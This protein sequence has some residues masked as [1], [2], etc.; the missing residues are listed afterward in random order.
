VGNSIS[1]PPDQDQRGIILHELD[2]TI[3]VEAAA[4][5]GKTTAM[6]GR[7][8]NL[9]ASGKCSVDTLAAVTFTRKAAA[10]LRSRF[11][12]QLEKAY[13]RADG[14]TGRLLK[15]ALSGLE[16]CFIG[17][18]HSFCARMLR[19]RPVEAGV[20]IAFEEIDEN[21][22]RTF[23]EQAWDQYVASLYADNSP[24]LDQLE[25]LGVEIGQLRPTFMR[26]ADYPDVDSWP[27]RKLSAPDPSSAV[28][29]LE[30]LVRHME[31][32]LPSLPE[33]YGNDKLMPKYRLIPLMFRQ[34]RRNRLPEVM[35]ILA[36]FK[37]AK[38]VQKLW[39]DGPGQAK[40]EEALWNEFTTEVAQ[41]LVKAWLEYRYEPLLA[42]IRP[43]V[44]LYDDL[45]RR[46]GKLNYQ[47]LLMCAARLLKD[48]PSV[49]EYFRKRFTHLLVD[50]FQDTDPVQ[51]EVL[52]YLTADDLNET[53]WRNCRPVPGSLFVVGD[54]KQSI[55]RFRRADIVTYNRVKQ[56]I[57][58]SSGLVAYLSANFRTTR[59][60]VDW[61]NTVFSSDFAAYPAECSPEYVPL[62]PVRDVENDYG[63][64]KIRT[65]WIPK[66]LR[67]VEEIVDLEAGIIART[68]RNAIDRGVP[69]PRTPREIEAGIEPKANPADFLIVTP[70]TGNLGVYGDKLQ[71]LGIPHQVTGGSALNQVEE[72]LLLHTCLA[73]II[74]PDNPVALVAVLRS[75]LFG[76]S[77][78]ALYEFKRCRGR[79]SFNS[80]VPSELNQAYRQFFEDAFARLKQYA[81]WMARIPAVAAIE[82]IIYDLG[83]AAKSAAAIGGDVRAGSLAKAVELLRSSQ[84]ESWTPAEIVA[85][86]AKI[87]KHEE[88]H[89]SVPARSHQSATVRIMNLHK[90]KGLE[91][92]IVFLADPSGRTNRAPNLH[93]DR[94]GGEAVGYM[95]IDGNVFSASS[96]VLAQPEQWDALAE[97]ENNFKK[98]ENLRLLYVAATRAGCGLT[99]SQRETFQNQNP[100]SY[101][102]PK[103][104]DFGETPDPGPQMPLPRPT[105]RL[106]DSDVSD[107]QASIARRWARATEH[108]YAVTSVKTAAVQRGKLTYSQGEHGTEWGSVIHIL[109]QSLMLNPESDLGNLAA[110][111]LAD[112]GLDSALAEDA[113]ETARSVTRSE[114]WLR[115]QTSKRVL[116]E[117]PFQILGAIEDDGSAAVPTILRGVVDLAFEEPDGWVIIDYKSDRVSE[118]H[119]D[120]LVDLYKPQVLSYSDAWR[121]ITGSPVIETGLYFTFCSRY[122]RV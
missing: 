23:R 16:R 4:G 115:A 72:L 80:A 95:T 58:M 88:N 41:P 76:I 40:A 8:V 98:A 63:V 101:F 49:R 50:E 11:Q 36:Q 97:K 94:S 82:K 68:I 28:I 2:R 29:A 17:T 35:E 1:I 30:Q 81:L 87:T 102:E 27:A 62:L 119:I 74:E 75:E 43:A 20:D 34:L 110:A 37:T 104:K 15:N 116:V 69:V 33:H 122:V 61:V 66:D 105:I 90:V 19:E 5:T 56:I 117:A 89:D 107:A 55:Y 47:D 112:Q 38:P 103:L 108:S 39:P 31:T 10:E 109:L 32:V 60:V 96:T 93:I 120:H 13:R 73:A 51:A 114:I 77:D 67:K 7:M 57:S 79:F 46:A 85:S 92:P 25:E 44:A 100:W 70:N 48:K 83:L 12:V 14:T 78:A 3:L 71:E 99:V 54:P 86:L 24:T 42:A 22:D 18:I 106:A 65:L 118:A 45:R 64:A 52:L 21:V 121:R 53:D 91:A 26:F 6:I 84:K 9:L 111:A 59:L 113:I